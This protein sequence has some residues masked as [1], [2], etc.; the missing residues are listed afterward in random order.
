MKMLISAAIVALP[1]FAAGAAHAASTQDQIA[2]CADALDERG[3][4]ARSEYQPRF[5][6][7]KGG[8]AKKLVL[9]MQPI[10]EGGERIVATCKIKRGK[11]TEVLVKV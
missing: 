2:M 6:S 1:M 10:A 4:A 3:V 8:G 5:K 11:V 7:I 9:E